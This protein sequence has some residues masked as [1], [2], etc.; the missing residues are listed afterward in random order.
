[1]SNVPGVQSTLPDLAE[2]KA[3]A[4]EYVPPPKKPASK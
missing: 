4:V 1:M 3:E 2:F